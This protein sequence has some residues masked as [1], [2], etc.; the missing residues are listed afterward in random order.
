MK[1]WIGKTIYLTTL[2][3]FSLP[4]LIT[5]S[6]LVPA[7]SATQTSPYPAVDCSGHPRNQAG[8]VTDGTPQCEGPNHSLQWCAGNDYQKD[9]CDAAMHHGYITSGRPQLDDEH[10]TGDDNQQGACKA[11]RRG[12]SWPPPQRA[13]AASAG[14][15][16]TI[17]S[18]CYSH[19]MSY[20]EMTDCFAPEVN[21][22]N[23]NTSE[24]FHIMFCES[25]GKTDA[26]NGRY[27]GLMQEDGGSTDPY[28][29]IRSA[30]YD[31]Y[32]QRGWEPW[33]CA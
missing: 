11:A 14:S 16:S 33:S 2:V 25:R 22:Y 7:A 8:Y 32:T 4:L 27:V 17:P 24:V 15:Q 31:Y 23:W 26:Y 6:S 1:S 30:Y 10:C 5:S 13:S 18:S 12:E 19:E 9:H 21:K 20:Q 29:N 3:A 28:V